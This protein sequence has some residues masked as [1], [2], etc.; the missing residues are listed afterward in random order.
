[1]RPNL[2]KHAPLV[3]L[4]VLATGC[5]AAPLPAPVADATG[6][7]L[8]NGGF[9]EGGKDIPT[10]WTLET[11]AKAKGEALV[12]SSPVHAGQH[13]AKLVPNG[14]N[15]EPT[16]LLSIGQGM[17]IDA[18]RGK[19][20]E[21]SAWLGAEGNA[22]AIAGVYAI[23]KTGGF[24]EGLRLTQS[25]GRSGLTHYQGR[26]VVPQDKESLFL[27]VSC[28]V[29]GTTGAAYFDDIAL[30]IVPPGG[31]VVA[32]RHPTDHLQAD[33]T[34]D[35]GRRIRPIPRT[36]YGT[37]IEWIFDGYGLWDAARD[38]LN[39]TLVSLTRDLGASLIRFPGGVFSDFY[40]WKNGVGP[41]GSRPAS[42][43][44]PGADKSPNH[45]GT[46]EAL[47]FARL[48]GGQLLITVNAGTGTPAEAADWVRYVNGKS[49]GK[50]QVT[51][52]EVGNELYGKDDSP[53]TKAVTTTPDVY[54]KRF[55]EFARAM[56][57][58]DPS[59]R[60]G[61]IGGENYGRY[62]MNGYPGW[63]RELLHRAGGEVDFL[64]VHNAYAPM[65]FI[66]R[67]ED[68]HTVYAA[69]L[70]TPILIAR[71]LE[72]LSKQIETF[73]PDRKDH[74]RLAVTEWGPWFH[75]EPQSR[76]LDHVKT[77]GSALYVAGTL[78]VFIE[79]PRMDVANAFKLVDNAYLGWIGL[80]DGRYVPKAP[81][82]AMQMFTRHF[83][84]ELVGS[85]VTG[86]TYDSPAV[87]L[88][89]AVRNVPYLDVIAS[90]NVAGDRL[91][92]MGINRHF[93]R[94]IRARITLH[95][96]KPG[97]PVVAWTLNG[98]GIDAH[99]GT[100]LP[101]IPGLNW[102]RQSVAIPGERFNHGGPDEVTVS[103]SEF[104]TVAERFEYAFPA[105][106]VTSLELISREE[107]D[108]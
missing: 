25:S 106:S 83:G 104:A 7:Y 69:M 90:R 9:E 63:N 97:T 11:A 12:T 68:V 70:A 29:E 91:Y 14:R 78:K 62:A 67:G 16:H 38:D 100:Q 36:L 53:A 76:F 101:K 42:A 80:R 26:F 41:R 60:I 2:L 57:A 73:V 77:L 40:H 99:T 98:S 81:Y 21:L 31:E 47:Q 46:D 1:M 96:F 56:R 66:D 44:V 45:F 84:T 35:A 37:N 18:L 72:T 64:S 107:A 17:G 61:A 19:T 85:S 74:I 59:I 30:R 5:N 24:S 89:D 65:I 50:P 108:R 6:N 34:V 32:S 3:F 48:V 10:G 51:Y 8:R 86:P 71:N 27:V 39:P 33:I 94:P 13:A 52:W 58:A 102:A 23:K 28:A 105:H 103:R 55:L 49:P 75:A 4:A 79:S 15:A 87:G 93:D 92:V 22:T 43:H 20:L 54:A 82:Y 88:V 95:G